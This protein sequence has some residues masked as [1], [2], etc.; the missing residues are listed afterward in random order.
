MGQR[1]AYPLPED[2]CVRWAGFPIE[3]VFWAAPLVCGFVL[4][5]YVWIGKS[6]RGMGIVPPEGFV[7]WMLI[8]LGV[9]WAARIVFR[10]RGSFARAQVGDLLEDMEVSQ[11]RP[12]A[13]E[14]EGEIVGHG[15]PGAFWSADLVLRDSTGL[16]FLYYRS[17][18]PFGRLFFALRSADRLIGEQV[19][20]RGWYR[21]GLKP[22]VEVA[23]V[24]SRVPVARGRGMVTLFGNKD[25]SA[26][27]E[28]EDLVERSYSQWIQLAATAV[29]VAAGVVLLLA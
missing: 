2:V 6:L 8:A 20:V 14:I 5:S 23:R 13:V 21:R 4:L 29:C 27:V 15:I 9:T 3:F 22:Y 7:A 11:M 18:I 10:Y 25:Q 16:M 24:E 12:R 1:G 17:S 19:K 26:P 28:Y